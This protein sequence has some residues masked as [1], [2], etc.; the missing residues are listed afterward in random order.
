[1]KRHL[2]MLPALTLTVVAF[3]A[4]PFA[5][6]NHPPAEADA[7]VPDAGPI[8]DVVIPPTCSSTQQC[9]GAYLL[10]ADTCVFDLEQPCGQGHCVELPASAAQCSAML[11]VCP[12]SGGTQ[13][14]PA[15]WDG[16]SPI[17]IQSMGPCPD[18]GS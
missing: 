14:V 1:M 8:D 17:P 4:S 9:Q 5:A 3:V 13:T 10:D 11:T 18:G 12:C 6:C 2:S 16:Q 7:D 15:C